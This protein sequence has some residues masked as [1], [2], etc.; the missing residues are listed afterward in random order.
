MRTGGLFHWLGIRV[1]VGIVAAMGTWLLVTAGPLGS[2][3]QAAASHPA[4]AGSTVLTVSPAPPVAQSIPVA[5]RPSTSLATGVA[6]PEE[7]G[8]APKLSS[9][10]LA[11]SLDSPVPAILDSRVPAAL[12]PTVLDSRAPT[13]LGGPVATVL[14]SGVPTAVNYPA[15]TTL[16]GQSRSLP[17][18]MS[19]SAM[20][21]SGCWGRRAHRAWTGCSHSEC[22]SQWKCGSPNM[23]ASGTPQPGQPMTGQPGT[24]QPMTGQPGTSQ[25]MTSQPGTS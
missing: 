2:V 12:A 11:V 1:F 21:S 20:S 24:G 18:R 9:Q 8:S 13:S 25:P 6:E 16:T 19:C 7:E 22:Y 5:L 10:Q 3:V 17:D 15:T 4:T 23:M 14:A